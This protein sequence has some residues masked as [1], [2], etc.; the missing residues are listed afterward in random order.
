MPNE[1]ITAGDNLP[2]EINVIIEIPAKSN[3]IKYELDKN[4]NAMFVDRFI[5][6]PMFYPCDYGFIPNTLSDDGDPADVLVI[7]PYPLMFGCVV[8]C[9]PVGMLQMSDESGIDAKIIAVP[10]DK[11][12]KEYSHIKDIEQ[13]S[14]LLRGQIEHFFSRYKDLEDGKWVKIDKW[15]GVKET[16]AEIIK[17]LNNAKNSN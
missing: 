13:V 12:T 6:T 17:A 11:L 2:D 3:P 10:T 4:T 9:R 7:A 15:Y 16:K 1:K 8:K 14:S 5:S